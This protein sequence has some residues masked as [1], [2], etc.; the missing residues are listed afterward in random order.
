MNTVR[1][2]EAARPPAPPPAPELTDD[3]VVARVLAGETALFEV[4]MRRHNQRLFRAARS[5]AATTKPRT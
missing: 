4:L 1:E 3:I 5:C 2:P